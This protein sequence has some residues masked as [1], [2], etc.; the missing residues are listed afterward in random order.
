VKAELRFSEN[1]DIENKLRF[2][3]D[4]SP[5]SSESYNRNSSNECAEEL[6]NILSAAYENAEIIPDLEKLM[7]SPTVAWILCVDVTIVQV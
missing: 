1:E 5:L 7:V 2:F 6:T 3:V 4:I